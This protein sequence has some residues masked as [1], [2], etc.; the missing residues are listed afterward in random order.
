MMTAVGTEFFGNEAGCQGMEPEFFTAE[1]VVSVRFR[2]QI[3]QRKTRQ[4][5]VCFPVP[6]PHDRFT[7]LG[8]P[9]PALA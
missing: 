5:I 4:K 7:D 1:P 6:E 9:A 3:D 2:R 8:D